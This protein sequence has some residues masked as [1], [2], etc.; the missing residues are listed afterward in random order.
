MTGLPNRRQFTEDVETLL[1]EFPD[2]LVTAVMLD[3]DHLKQY[4]D[5]YGHPAGDRCLQRIAASVGAANGPETAT[6]YRLGGEEFAAL[7]TTGTITDAEAAAQMM[8]DV[9]AAAGIESA[10]PRRPVTVSAGLAVV[11]QDD[12]L[13]AMMARA[14]AAL[15]NAKRTGRNRLVVDRSGL[16]E[17]S[18]QCV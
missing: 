9:V 14:D 2:A 3:V 11:C 8:V 4:N 7:I 16:S 12:D 17:T 18:D 5:A 13:N 15:Y 10:D 1:R 6:L